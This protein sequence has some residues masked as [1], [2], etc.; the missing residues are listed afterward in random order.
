MS[1]RAEVVEEGAKVSELSCGYCFFFKPETSKI[2]VTRAFPYHCKSTNI[3]CVF[4]VSHRNFRQPNHYWA[5]LK[6]IY[7]LAL[8]SVPPVAV[9][10]EDC[11]GWWL[12]GRC[13]SVAE[14]WLHKPGVLGSISI[15]CMRSFH[16]PP[17]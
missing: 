5:V 4:W 15:D 17:I 14:S 9:H 6:K 12:F 11:G 10:I 13:C 3:S 2:N 16:F 7:I 8:I 1:A